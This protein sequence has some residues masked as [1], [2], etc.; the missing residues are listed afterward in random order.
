M[1]VPLILPS[2]Y[3]D[4]KEHFQSGDEIAEEFFLSEEGV[5]VQFDRYTLRLWPISASETIAAAAGSELR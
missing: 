2:G 3:A 5:S 4:L 1:L